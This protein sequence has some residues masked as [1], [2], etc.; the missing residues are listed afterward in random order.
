LEGKKV[1]NFSTAAVECGKVSVE[2]FEP[3]FSY[4]ARVEKM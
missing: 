4:T 3:D 2:N 1:L